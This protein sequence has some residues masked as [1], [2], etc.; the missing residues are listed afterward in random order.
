MDVSGLVKWTEE[1][2]AYGDGGTDENY[3]AYF[4]WKKADSAQIIFRF[5]P[6]DMGGQDVTFDIA[7]RNTE[8]VENGNYKPFDGKIVV[9]DTAGRRRKSLFPPVR[10]CTRRFRCSFIKPMRC[11]AE[12]NG[13]V[14]CRRSR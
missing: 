9:K 2:R 7:D 10:R 4:K 11:L 13:S 3:A 1:K 5:A 8:R 14:R 6:Y 12:K